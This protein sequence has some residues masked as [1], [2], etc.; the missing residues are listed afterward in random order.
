MLQ[1]RTHQSELVRVFTG[2]HYLFRVLRKLLQIRSQQASTEIPALM[3]MT[4]V[5]RAQDEVECVSGACAVIGH[6]QVASMDEC[7]N[8]KD[9]CS[10]IRDRRI[11]LCICSLLCRASE[12]YIIFELQSG[13]KSCI[14]RDARA[15]FMVLMLVSVS[16]APTWRA[17]GSIQDEEK[18]CMAPVELKYRS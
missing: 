5:I 10:S 15:I 17:S 3:S 1:I 6:T 7:E 2:R 8:L 13:L 16:R 4:E 9:I 12:L 14:M 11:V 18:P